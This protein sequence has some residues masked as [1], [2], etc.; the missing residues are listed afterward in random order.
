VADTARARDILGFAP[1]VGLADAVAR[2]VR[3]YRSGRV[4]G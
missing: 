4:Q 2:T 3:W 1:E